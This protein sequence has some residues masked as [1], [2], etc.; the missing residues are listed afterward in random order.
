MALK[1]AVLGETALKAAAVILPKTVSC[2]NKVILYSEIYRN[3]VP[4]TNNIVVV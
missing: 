4:P 3:K 1:P 2:C